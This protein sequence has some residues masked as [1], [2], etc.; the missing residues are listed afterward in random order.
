MNN[1]EKILAEYLDF[2]NYQKTLSDKTLKAYRIDLLQFF[3]QASVSDPLNVTP[4][5][6]DDYIIKLHHSYKPKTV[7]RKIASLKAFFHYLKF[8][9]LI[10]ENPFDRVYVKF[11]EPETLP[12]I[13][14][15]YN[16]EKLLH[17]MYRQKEKHH[18]EFQQKLL[19]RDLLLIELLFSTGM[20]ISEIC[21]IR[22][23]DISADDSEILI[24]GKGAKERMIQICDHQIISLLQQY[25]SIYTEQIT[26]HGY[27]F[28][29]H[30][31]TRLSE[32]SVRDILKKYVKLAGI[33]QHITPHMFRH[34]FATYLLEADVDIRYIQTLLG[35]SS[36]QTTE[37]YTHVN[38]AKQK[39]ILS[40]KLPKIN[41]EI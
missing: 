33:D 41:L 3:V 15:L 37:I 32:Q 24:H 30:N 27:F 2:C 40:T 17:T 12:R 18:S 29:S 26:P 20:R 28:L 8:K 9:D 35:H 6:L 31:G 19:V 4:P 25:K 11:R 7:K 13:I 16:I 34:S 1:S 39:Q 21:N 22:P 14:P 38:M 23:C 5:A 10:S 36:I